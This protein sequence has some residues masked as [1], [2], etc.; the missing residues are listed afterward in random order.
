MSQMDQLELY[1]LHK[2]LVEWFVKKGKTPKDVIS[3]LTATWIGQMCLNGYDEEFFDAT[4]IH[5]KKRWRE[6]RLNPKKFMNK[7][8]N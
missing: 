4:L 6:H 3:F 8:R 5:M 7:P 2:Y 1:E